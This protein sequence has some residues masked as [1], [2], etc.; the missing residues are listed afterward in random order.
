MNTL[1]RG[2]LVLALSLLTRPAAAQT[3]FINELH[4]DN[5]GTDSGER[6]EVAGP[7]GTDLS[8]WTLILYNGSGGVTYGSPIALSGSIPDLGAGFGV[9]APAALAANGIQNGAPDGLALVDPLGAV[10][11]FLSY[12]GSFA[13]TN[14]PASGLTSTDIGVSQPG[15]GASGQSLRLSGS[16]RVY[17]DFVWN[18]EAPSSFGAIN[19][20]Q[21]FIAAGDAAPFV[22]ATNPADGAV[23]VALDT[24]LTVSFS[25]AVST[26]EAAFSLLCGGTSQPFGFTAMAS[27]VALD[28]LMDL[29]AASACTLTI[30]ASG[31]V[32]Q[33]G[34]ADPLAADQIVSFQTA[35]A[36]FA[37]GEPA[38]P[39]SAIQGSGPSAALTGA[40]VV[41]A[42]V[43]GVYSGTP[44][45]RGFYI[46]EEPADEDADPATSEG[47]FVFSTE[48]VSSGEWIR[49]AASAGDFS[50]QTQLSSVTQIARC[51]MAGGEA[52]PRAAELSL[53]LPSAD[54]PE[55]FEG[56][57][58]RF[59]Q[60]LTV[61]ETFVLGRFGEVLLSSERLIQPTQIVAPGGPA[62]A[63]Q[64]ANDL[65]QIVLDDGNA[66]QNPAVVPYP[67][68]A[69][70]ALNPLR[71]GD[72][73][74]AL[75]G[76]LGF[77]FNAY[78][79]QPLGSVPFVASNPRPAAPPLP[80]AGNLRV[81]SFNVLN[82]FNGDGAGG[83]FPTSRGADS[84]EEFTRQRDKIIAAIVAMDADVIG[85]IEIENDGYGPTSAIQ[86]LV[87]GVN[88]AVPAGQGYALIDPGVARI[89]TD[90]I[91]VGFIYRTA[92][93]QPVGAAAILD[94]RVN[95]LFV[96]TLNRPAL[97]QSFALADGGERLTLVINHFKS[98]GSACPPP[99]TDQGDGQGNCN[100]T[101]TNAAIA[102]A[103]WLATDPT[104]SGDAD[105]LILGDLNSYRREDPIGVLEDAGYRNLAAPGAI[106]YVFDGQ[107]GTL[108]YALASPTLAAQVLAAVEWNINADEAIALDYNT[109]FKSPA[110][111]LSYYSPDPFRSS[112]HDPVVVAL[113]LDSRAPLARSLIALDR[114]PSNR[115][116]VRYELRFDQPVSGVDRTDLQLV[117]TG[118]TGAGVVQVSGADDRYEIIL[119]TGSG[120]GEIGVDLIDN[121]SIRSLAG[122]PLGGV[123]SG[124][125]GR[126][127][128][129]MVIDRSAPQA[130]IGLADGQRSPTA[131]PELLFSLRFSEPVSGLVAS[132]L[133]LDGGLAVRSLDLAGSGRD[134]R[135]RVLLEPQQ[136]GE[137]VLVL[138][139]Q[140][141]FDAAGNLSAAARSE[142]VRLTPRQ[143]SIRL[144][145]RQLRAVEPLTGV[146]RLTVTAELSTA[147][148]DPLAVE[149]REQPGRSS[150]ER[151]VDYTL[152]V[153]FFRFAP[154]QTRAEAVIELRA[155]ALEEGEETAWLRLV[156]LPEGLTADASGRLRL[157][158]QD[159][160]SAPRLSFASEQSVALEGRLLRIPVQLDRASERRISTRVELLAGS[161]DGSDI[162]LLGEGEVRI[163]AGET[164]GL[165]RIEVL[166]DGLAEGEETLVLELVE[167]PLA[168]LAEPSRHR[169]I[170]RD[171]DA[172]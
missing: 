67:A 110:Q 169:L 79:V 1:I 33:D 60:T 97:A 9:V 172:P 84:A 12:E 32:D 99:D 70:S 143:A 45:L 2:C 81:A 128:P 17:S 101:R 59:P 118:L 14:G 116:F 29:P 75:E 72:T 159:A 115:S 58:V 42:V 18:S 6:I 144:L 62:M 68:P 130:E 10:V 25:E 4:Y 134:Y 139:P 31:V 158:L 15:T 171:P 63:Q 165:L 160:G 50:G 21:F 19:A 22:T 149:L 150:A 11:Q 41:E 155:D 98:K 38:T 94:S 152:P 119:S 131:N 83:G 35:A 157:T 126:S 125:G 80:A 40:V 8:G 166:A 34:T 47:L 123:G 124:N 168:G 133:S 121:D 61:S 30:S 154:G 136:Q 114:V 69:L 56:M 73:V 55:R 77:G 71:G 39:I 103:D 104:G 13:A 140:A 148:S 36:P 153:N 122:T 108:D 109:E 3:V 95:P 87:N 43:T 23:D 78:R 48:T 91:A 120:D 66:Q 26:S 27:S 164:Q 163:A 7:A 37:C 82:Y 100:L 86:D 146:K 161:A 20:D 113:D 102:L 24:T 137:A 107:A 96:D 132:S 129:R 44:G 167:P 85:L 5:T 135:V 92:R 141:G 111:Q 57:R 28:P 106:G 112:D 142:P 52:L 89:G 138:A 65:N 170:L 76:V 90:E 105:V 49:L 88:A 127:G 117:A 74:T 54:F 46:Q 151:G 145:S 147:L 16:G 53:P 156:D 93:V 51:G 162:R 64:A